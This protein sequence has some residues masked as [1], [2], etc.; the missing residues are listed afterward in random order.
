MVEN[1]ATTLSR[2]DWHSAAIGAVLSVIPGAQCAPRSCPAGLIAEV[3]LRWW[4]HDA[5]VYRMEDLDVQ[6]CKISLC[7]EV[8]DCAI[9]NACCCP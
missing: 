8:S 4:R 7:E 9:C 3:G 1:S 6:V 2:K 5:A